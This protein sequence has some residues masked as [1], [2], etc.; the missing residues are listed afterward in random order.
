MKD[1]MIGKIYSFMRA[2]ESTSIKPTMFYERA[3]WT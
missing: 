2:G 3:S 1:K